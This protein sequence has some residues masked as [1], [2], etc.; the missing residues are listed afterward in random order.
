MLRDS[1]V[2]RRDLRRLR[3]KVVGFSG[4]GGEVDIEEVRR[5]PEKVAT[6]P[7]I[8][9]GRR[10]VFRSEEMRRYSILRWVKG[11]L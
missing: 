2:Q 5:V 9:A 6:R 4:G 3:V 8:V 10:V 1:K 7:K 11:L